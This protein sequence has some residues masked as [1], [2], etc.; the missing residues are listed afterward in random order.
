MDLWSYFK[1][2]GIMNYTLFWYA[3]TARG[4]STNRARLICCGTVSVT[5]QDGGCKQCGQTAMIWLKTLFMSRLAVCSRD[6]HWHWI[7][8]TLLCDT[9]EVSMLRLV[10]LLIAQHVFQPAL[11]GMLELIS[12]KI[13]SCEQEQR[14]SWWADFTIIVSR[15]LDARSY[16]DFAKNI[17]LLG[18]TSAKFAR[19]GQKNG[20][21]HATAIYPIPWYTTAIYREYTI[22]GKMLFI[23][24]QGLESYTKFLYPRHSK[25]VGSVYWFHSVRPFV[26]PASSVRS[27]APAF[28]VGSISYLCILSSNLRCVMCRVEC[29]ISKFEFL[30]IFKNL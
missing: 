18:A 4:I 24:K 23:L 29:K 27:V 2:F 7:N 1:S 15:E 3:C 19:G 28:M 9:M 20:V 11:T 14:L 12:R 5:G 13:D 21:Q 30:A 10:W 17:A 22:L 26:C 8:W 6:L 25:V 16:R